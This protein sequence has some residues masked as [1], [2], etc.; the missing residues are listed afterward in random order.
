M[1]RIKVS[2]ESTQKTLIKK[3]LTLNIQDIWTFEKDFR[4][5]EP[6]LGISRGDRRMNKIFLYSFDLFLTNCN[7]T[8]KKALLENKTNDLKKIPPESLNLS[9][10]TIFRD[11]FIFKKRD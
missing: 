6:K 3:K 11:C 4:K 7:I 9:I 10:K 8:E 5:H 2:F 1:A